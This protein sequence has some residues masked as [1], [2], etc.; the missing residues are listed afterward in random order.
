MPCFYLV[1]ILAKGTD[2]TVFTLQMENRASVPLILIG[3]AHEIESL[4]TLFSE[5]DYFSFDPEKVCIYMS[6][7]GSFT[8]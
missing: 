3:S 4:K 8:L 6:M 5:N 1:N 7:N 2:E